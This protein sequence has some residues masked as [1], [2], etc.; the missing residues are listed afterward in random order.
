MKQAT[1]KLLLS[2]LGLFCLATAFA[3]KDTTGKGGVTI[4]S[5]F[6]P[7]LREAAKINFNA[8]PPAADTTKPR[9]N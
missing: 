7:V 5:S 9:L 2:G 8:T 3:Q 4:V 1:I 6:K